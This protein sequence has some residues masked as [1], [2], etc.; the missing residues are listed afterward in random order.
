MSRQL[1]IVMY[2][3]VRDLKRSRY[4]AIKGLTTSRFIGQIDYLSSRYHFVTIEDCLQTLQENTPLPPN[5]ALLTFDDGYIDHFTTVFPIL[6]ARGIQGAF[7]PPSRAITQNKVLG[8]NKIHFILAAA[9]PLELKENFIQALDEHRGEFNLAD[10]GD[11]LER[12]NLPNRF[13]PPEVNFIKRMLQRELP[14][15][16]RE[17]LADQFFKQYVASN[18]AAF[19]RELYMDEPQL[20]CMIRNG[21][22]VGSHGHGHFWMNTLSP[23]KQQQDLELSLDFLEQIGAPTRNWVMSYPY[24]AYN[25]SLIDIVRQHNGSLGLTT[26]VKVAEITPDSAFT[27]PRLDTN[28]LPQPEHATS[29]DP[30]DEPEAS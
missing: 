9:N 29:A 21:M 22:Y 11:Y 27:L 10:T 7:F 14:E 12:L 16:L 23:A 18:E 30:S 28:D 2:H 17:R 20:K 6:N 24:G 3:F 25:A 1:T 26:E 8:V 5:A 4:P 13:D 15:S 19:A